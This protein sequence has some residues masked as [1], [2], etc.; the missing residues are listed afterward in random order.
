MNLRE[1]N[2]LIA[3]KLMNV[4][5]E[6]VDGVR[7]YEGHCDPKQYSGDISAA[8]EVVVKLSEQ[9]LYTRVSNVAGLGKWRCATNGRI[10][11]FCETAPMAIC[12]AALNTIGIGFIA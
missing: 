3:E 10:T 7:Y 6:D 9:G 4:D 5:F 12:L 2:V 1:I 8:W 11:D